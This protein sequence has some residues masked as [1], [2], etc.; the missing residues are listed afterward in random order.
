M[1]CET[2]HQGQQFRQQQQQHNQ[3]ERYDCRQ[4]QQQEYQAKQPLQENGQQYQE[5]KQHCLDRPLYYQQ[6]EQQYQAHQTQQQQRTQ[7]HQQHHSQQVQFQEPQ[8]QQ[9]QA[10]N[11]QTGVPSIVTPG[12]ANAPELAPTDGPMPPLE[13]LLSPLLPSAGETQLLARLSHLRMAL[14]QHLR[15]AT[16]W[17]QQ[18]RRASEASQR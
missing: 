17:E 6:Q 3:I 2:S 12:A 16:G 8:Q 18:V 7:A 15:E 9:G 4:Q 14:E 13:V 11:G 1:Q 10:G 5:Q